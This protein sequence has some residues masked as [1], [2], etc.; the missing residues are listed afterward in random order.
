[1]NSINLKKRLDFV[2]PRYFKGIVGGAETLVGQLA[3]KLVENGFEVDILTTCAK[4]NRT[5]DNELPAG[6][7][8]TDLLKIIRFP[9][10]DRNLESWIPKQIAISEG[11]ELSIEDQL[12]WMQES[13]N[14]KGLYKHILDSKDNYDSFFFAPYMFGT[15]FW[16]SL[17]HPEKSILIP[18]LHN[19]AYA[20]LEIMQ[21]MFSE[22]KGCL[23]NCNAE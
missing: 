5:W 20:Y 1:M 11:M 2:L 4:D 17:I 10:D 22:V 9:V 18:C 16:G 21:S 15:T 14:S 6:I 3:E 19:E 12:E 7:E 23:F 8:K 13:V